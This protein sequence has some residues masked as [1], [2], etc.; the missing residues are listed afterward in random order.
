MK[1]IYPFALLIFHIVITS[2]CQINGEDETKTQ[3]PPKIEYGIADISPNIL[4][5]GDTLRISGVFNTEAI[6]VSVSFHR[7]KE[8]IRDSI[9]VEVLSFSKDEL[10]A[11]AYQY[12][13]NSGDFYIEVSMDKKF[14]KSNS[15]VYLM[16]QISPY[17]LSTP[18][19]ARVGEM[20]E[21]RGP[22]GEHTD[23]NTV[24][25]KFFGSETWHK[26]IGKDTSE[27]QPYIKSVIVRVPPD[28]KT[29]KLQMLSVDH[30]AGPIQRQLEVLPRNPLPTK[31]EWVQVAN[32]GWGEKEY[33]W[34]T[35]SSSFTIDKKAYVVGGSSGTGFAGTE[36]NDDLWEYNAEHDS[37]FPQE[38]FP[39]DGLVYG[40]AFT[41]D[42]IGYVGTGM[43][44]QNK[45]TSAFYSY[46]PQSDTWER[47]ADFPG[48]KRSNAVGFVVNGKGYLG[49]GKNGD[50]YYND[51]Y[52]YDPK[53]DTWTPIP[54]I[55]GNRA[56]AYA[57]AGSN[58]GF[59]G[60][61]RDGKKKVYDLYAYDPNS[62]KW[63]AKNDWVNSN[64]QVA[65]KYTSAN[66]AVIFGDHAYVGLG[67]DINSAYSFYSSKTILKYSIKED[68]WSVFSEYQGSSRTHSVGFVIDGVAYF[69]LGVAILL[70]N[71]HYD[72][73]AYKF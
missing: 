3:E 71:A 58:L 16:P 24:Q 53:T 59:V 40:V 69:G 41:I 25:I 4:R 65:H 56:D 22:L 20:I 30:L 55:P 15:S 52:E 21:L 57:F 2:S 27:L 14:Y 17:F 1:S 48:T 18:T 23:P 36:F 67:Y 37:W 10:V 31:D 66:A 49:S 11:I 9:H 46:D 51:F 26:T 72:F 13:P 19:S 64:N 68:K 44:N 42:G 60:A 5:P 29:G 33:N 50:Q 73:W 62:Q 32:M 45:E 7:S 28:A 12:L 38:A 61:G 70:N 43:D 6:D 39:G 34:S 8:Y 35:G 54:A 47:K 63:T